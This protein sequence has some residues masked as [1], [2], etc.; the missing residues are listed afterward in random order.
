MDNV[1]YISGIEK[2]V[3][4]I[5]GI[6]IKGFIPGFIHTRTP[7]FTMHIFSENVRTTCSEKHGV[8]AQ[9]R[10]YFFGRFSLRSSR[11]ICSLWT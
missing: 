2:I 10:T 6:A 9:A 4:H 8:R 7:C 3:K 11:F 1:A 5:P